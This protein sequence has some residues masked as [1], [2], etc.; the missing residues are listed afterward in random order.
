MSSLQKLSKT[1]SQARRSLWFE[2]VMA[3]LALL[4]L[5]LVLF[6]LSYIPLRD[7]WLQGRIQVF[8]FNVGKIRFPGFTLPVPL[9]PITEW[10]DPVKGIEGYR[11]TVQYLNRVDELETQMQRTG[12]RSPQVEAILQDLRRRSVE[13]IDTNPFE[14]ANK[15]GTLEKIKNRMRVLIPNE[16][17]SSKDAFTTFWSQDYLATHGQAQ[18]LGFFR[19]KIQPLIE[20]NYYRPIGEN[21]EFIDRFWIIDLPF[22]F[23][24]GIEFLARTWV[25][26]RRHIG[27]N[28]LDAMLWRWY[29]IFLLLPFWR[30]LRV[31]PVTVRLN[32]AE[33]LDLNRIQ[34]QISQGFVATMAEDLTEVVVVSIINQVQGSI[35][36]G[37]LAKWLSQRPVRPYVDINNTDEVAA[38]STLMLQLMVHRVLPKIRPDIEA[39]LQYHIEKILNQSPAYRGLQ[40]VP[41]LE[42]VQ[43]EL[44]QRLVK[45]ICQGI[46][47]GLNSTLEEDPVGEQLFKRLIEHLSEAIGSEIQAKQTLHRIQ[48]LLTDLLEEV[49]INYVE[50]LSEEDLESVLEQTRALR[51][52]SHKELP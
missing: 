51:Q 10:Y 24:F 17:D 49:K 3:S 14:I 43:H 33:L 44:T 30:W 41:G 13:M 11:D 28:W 15:T 7:F 35:R 40:Q 37:D 34:K 39:L 27:V 46:Y 5:L 47:D 42:Q 23:L 6:D 16:Q 2:R 1:K 26:S 29:D 36:S 4:N 48:S 45:E 32:Q 9:P 38:L 22:V 8:G 50:R 21:G 25:I 52:I 31:I 20:T 18:G 12:V 19:R